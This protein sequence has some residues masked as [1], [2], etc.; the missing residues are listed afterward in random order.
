MTAVHVTEWDDRGGDG[1]GADGDPAVFVHN[2]FTWGSDAVYGFAGQ[3]PL[4]DSRR[5]LL[6][7]RRGYGGSP[8]VARSD[9]EEDAADVLELLGDGAHL[10]GHGN[11]AV[12]ALL[13]AA[14][15]PDLVR[16]LAL[17]QPSAFTAA[18]DRPVVADL[19]DRVREG[20][21]AIP[22]EVTPEQ[23]LRASTEG[24]GMAMP[25]PTPRRLRAVTTSMRE[26]PVWEAEIPLKPIQNAG[27]PVLLICGT[28]ENAPTAY[29]EHVGLPL[30]AVAESLAESFGG[31]LL[32]VPGY[33]PHTQQP[34]AVNAA[35]GEFWSFSG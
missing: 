1:A 14:H 17:I 32:R 35:L 31:G 3:R 11:G 15:R 5:L 28:W 13:A 25:D 29:R 33:Y 6:M 34:A 16:S 30:M 27:V 23:Y 2:I 26:R 19:L 18:A 10:V 24:L 9:F 4:A 7:D 8:D 20:V 21:P 22:A 12:A